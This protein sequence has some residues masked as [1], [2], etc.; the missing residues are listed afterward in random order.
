MWRCSMGEK[1]PTST[2]RVPAQ[3]CR[4][5]CR[6]RRPRVPPHPGQRYAPAGRPREPG[7]L[8]FKVQLAGSLADNCGRNSLPRGPGGLRRLADG[9]W[10][11]RPDGDPAA[12]HARRRLGVRRAP[13]PQAARPRRHDDDATTSCS[14]SSSTALRRGGMRR[15]TV[16]EECAG[17]AT[18]AKSARARTGVGTVALR[19]DTYA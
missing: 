16:A 10:R 17:T 19:I 7:G 2:S 1:K 5:G 13:D 18:R 11:G 9:D 6:S 14:A 4:K 8:T 12:P 15:V 3:C